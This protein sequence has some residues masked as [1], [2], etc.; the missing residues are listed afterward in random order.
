M[1]SDSALSVAL[2][3]SMPAPDNA[4]ICVALR[5]AM[6]APVPVSVTASAPVSVTLPSAWYCAKVKESVLLLA[7]IWRTPASPSAAICVA[8]SAA[9][10][11]P[12]SVNVM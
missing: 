6:L 2:S 3:V 1:V 5:A 10:F 11:V 12:V 9:R 4:A 8:V 7:S